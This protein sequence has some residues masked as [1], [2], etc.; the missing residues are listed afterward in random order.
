M[1]KILLIALAMAVTLT[2]TVSAFAN[3][4]VIPG[5]NDAATLSKTTNAN[6][7]NTSKKVVTPKKKIIQNR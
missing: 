7:T 2:F 4:R 3:V 6:Q 5:V 1:K